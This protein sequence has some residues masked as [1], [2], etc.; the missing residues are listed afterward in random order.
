[1]FKV[2]AMDAKLVNNNKNNKNE[3]QLI[4]IKQNKQNKFLINKAL[5]N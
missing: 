1:M 4:Y 5:I 2:A 3:L